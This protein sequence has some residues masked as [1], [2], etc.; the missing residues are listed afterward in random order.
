MVITFMKGERMMKKWILALGAACALTT[1]AMA[2]GG[3][4]RSCGIQAR[5][6]VLACRAACT[7]EFRNA[8]FL[9][10]DVDPA[11]GRQCLGA[12]EGCIES[13]VQPLEDCITGCQGTLASEKSYCQQSCG[14][15]TGCLDS[16]FDQAQAN[17]FTCRDNCRESFVTNGGPAAVD[18][19]RQS[20]RSCVAQCPPP[21][22]TP[23]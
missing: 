2:T 21:G 4:D 19:C 8:K 6:D 17:A 5:E 10:K 7:D 9:C 18:L 14:E 11:C 13:A 23:R 20:F 22:Q 1:A 16:C 12:R 15:N 3:P